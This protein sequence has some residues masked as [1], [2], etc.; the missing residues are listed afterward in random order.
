MAL[1]NFWEQD[2]RD[3]KIILNFAFFANAM[4]FKGAIHK[5]K[6]CRG[7][8]FVLNFTVIL[9]CTLSLSWLLDYDPYSLIEYSS[10]F[11]SGDYYD[12][13]YHANTDLPMDN[14]IVIVASDHITNDRLPEVLKKIADYGAAAIGFDLM[15]RNESSISDELI[16]VVDSLPQ[17]VMP[18]EL[19]LDNES[20]LLRRDKPS[21]IDN[22]VNGK[23]HAT[24]SFPPH[25]VMSFQ[26]EMFLNVPLE[27][28]DS[29]DS[30][31]L[32]LAKMKNPDI[33]IEPKSISQAINFNISDVE[34]IQYD[35]FIDPERENTISSLIKDRIVLVGDVLNKY[36]L[37][38]TAIDDNMPGIKVHSAAISTLLNN[39]P[40]IPLARVWSIIL[41][42]LCVAVVTIVDAYYT[43]KDDFRKGLAILSI[44][45]IFLIPI[46]FGGYA[47]YIYFGIRSDFT[48]S[49]T[50]YMFSMVIADLWFGLH[51]FMAIRKEER[52]SESQ[53]EKT[54]ENQ[55]EK[56]AEES[57][58]ENKEESQDEKTEG[59]QEENNEC[60]PQINNKYENSVENI[61][62]LHDADTGIHILGPKE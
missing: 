51:K 8:E 42:V 6:S 28:G 38:T 57:R 46:L 11:N 3:P 35:E 34:V 58:D 2:T 16:E 9:I 20:G 31:A 21:L 47:L 56:E 23:L 48:Y 25:P 5:L 29:I 17:I 49:I 4:T 61:H 50:L 62:A 36:D 18:V 44:K 54:E 13:I 30:F 43:K 19:V 27:D 22:Y 32:A 15:F 45:G 7:G 12:R 26:R 1:S 60:S 14:D 41:M 24:V 39:K 37:H 33:K 52:E 59:N 55:E 40:V 53:E 10:D